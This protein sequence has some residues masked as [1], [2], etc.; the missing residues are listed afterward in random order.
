MTTL[1]EQACA[2]IMARMGALGMFTVARNETAP[3]I[4]PAGGHVV[5][6]DGARDSVDRTLGVAS[7]WVTHRVAVEAIAG[8]A[9]PDSALDALL[10]AI[11]QALFAE[12][13]LGGLVSTLDCELS[14]IET[15]SGDG[16]ETFKAA[17]IDVV[18]EYETSNPLD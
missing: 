12:P 3:A 16:A 11:E 7:W 10:G 1:R 5:V 18:I 2:A 4:I 15:I 8:G 17:L 14:E 13:T 9:D 6:R